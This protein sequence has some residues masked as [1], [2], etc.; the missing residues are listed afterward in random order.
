LTVIFFLTFSSSFKGH[1]LSLLPCQNPQWLWLLVCCCTGIAWRA[2]YH[3]FNTWE[4]RYKKNAPTPLTVPAQTRL[5]LEALTV[6]YH[7]V[8]P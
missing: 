2:Q 1:M 3:P 4:F 6:L 8:V 7:E 5:E